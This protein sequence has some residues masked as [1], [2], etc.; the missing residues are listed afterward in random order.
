MQGTIILPCSCQHKDQDEMYGKGMR[1]HNIS[2]KAGSELAYCTVC[3]PRRLSTEKNGTEIS[4][5]PAFGMKYP[6]PAVKPRHGKPIPKR[7]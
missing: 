5:S 6:I 4:A 7:A 1:V 2:G 3:T